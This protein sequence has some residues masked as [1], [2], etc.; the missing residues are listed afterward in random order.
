LL[1]HEICR[2]SKCIKRECKLM[3]SRSWE[4]GRRGFLLMG[5]VYLLSDENALPTGDGCPTL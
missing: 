4:K 1:S 5:I 2:V 3:V